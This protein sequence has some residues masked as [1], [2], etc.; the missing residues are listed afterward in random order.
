MIPTF[1]HARCS[2]HQ[3]ALAVLILSV[4]VY[5]S[6]VAAQA[7]KKVT[8]DELIQIVAAEKSTSDADLAKKL[9]DVE[10]RNLCA[11]A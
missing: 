2:V 11:G 6:P 9:T 3:P 7:L 1:N 8:A 4:S 5:V 10:L